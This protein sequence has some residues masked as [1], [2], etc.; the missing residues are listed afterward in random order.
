LTRGNTYYFDV[1]TGPT[2]PFW[3]KTSPTTGSGNV[4]STGVTN[5]GTYS[6]T[7]T[8]TVPSNAPNTLYYA[9]ENHNTMQGTINIIPTTTT[10]TQGSY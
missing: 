8:F 6:N 4:Y 2:H 9:C 5:N 1:N 7:I 10:T 3:I